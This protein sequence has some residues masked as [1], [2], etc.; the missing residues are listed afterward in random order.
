MGFLRDFAVEIFARS[1]PFFLLDAAQSRYRLS[2]LPQRIAGERRSACVSA[3]MPV[4]DRFRFLIFG[5]KAML[6]FELKDVPRSVSVAQRSMPCLMLWSPSS[7]DLSP[8]SA[9]GLI[10]PEELGDLRA[11]KEGLLR[12]GLLMPLGWRESP[13]TD[14]MLPLVLATED[15]E[16]EDD[17]V[18]DDDDEDEEEDE[19]E[20]DFFP[21]DADEFEDE[22]EE[23]DD[24]DDD[25]EDEDE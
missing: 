4:S 13:A 23:D 17:V 25:D 14:D 18:D 2:P 21:D 22:E 10:D 5:V 11:G 7:F 20:D 24:D 8:A 1:S 9:P 12:G 15:W 6:D 3:Q 19:D 16:D